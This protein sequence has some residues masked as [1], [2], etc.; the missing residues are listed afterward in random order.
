MSESEFSTPKHSKGKPKNLKVKKLGTPGFEVHPSVIHGDSPLKLIISTRKRKSSPEPLTPPKKI[1]MGDKAL[2][3]EM[4]EMFKQQEDRLT[5]KMDE[6]KADLNDKIEGMKTEL[7]NNIENLDVKEQ[8]TTIGTNLNSLTEAFNQSQNE[9]I[10]FESRVESIEKHIKD[11]LDPAKLAQDILPFIKKGMAASDDISW[12]AN[13]ARIVEEHEHSMI[14]HGYKIDGDEVRAAK[15]FLTDEM[16]TPRSVLD[17]VKIKEVTVLGK[18]NDGKAPA[19]LVR[20]AH[21]AQ[22]NTVITYSKNLKKG[23]RV[24]KN[25]PKLYQNEHKEFKKFQQKFRDINPSYKTQI[26]FDGYLM[27]LRYKEK[28]TDDSEYMWYR[29]KEYYPKPVDSVVTS[30][31]ERL[32]VGKVNSAIIPMSPGSEITRS[33]IVSG[34]KSELGT[35]E[36]KNKFKEYLSAEDLAKIVR[37]DKGGRD[38]YVLICT[39]WKDCLPIAEKYKEKFLGNTVYFNA[40]CL[41]DPALC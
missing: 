17:R 21:P 5:A 13:L 25:V 22:R 20:F 27:V 41:K 10:V 12:K 23:Y 9:K 33:I 3:K 24:D 14:I 37:I 29:V 35:E 16:K 1:K 11:N 2:M 18:G 40:F 38:S 28:D 30:P 15:D 6:D 8:I 32:E 39:Q 31:K 7:S 19:I 4:K 26:M 36:V 34:V